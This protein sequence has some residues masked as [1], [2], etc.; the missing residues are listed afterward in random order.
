[1][2]DVSAGGMCCWGRGAGG[3]GPGVVTLGSGENRH[4][5]NEEAWMPQWVHS[6]NSRIQGFKDAQSSRAKETS[7]AAGAAG[8]QRQD[9]SNER[10]LAGAP[11]SPYCYV[12][13][14]HLAS[15]LSFPGGLLLHPSLFLESS[16]CRTCR[17]WQE[18]IAPSKAPC[19]FHFKR[20]PSPD[21]DLRRYLGS[22]WGA[23]YSA[24][25]R[26]IC[27]MGPRPNE[28]LPYP[29]ALRFLRRG[30]QPPTFSRH[31]LGPLPKVTGTAAD[32]CQDL[33]AGASLVAHSPAPAVH[34]SFLH[35]RPSLGS[36]RD[37]AFA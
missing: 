17:G 33:R 12:I 15:F 28:G 34:P 13:P 19:P 1:M 35:G 22:A 8:S 5:N 4:T 16:I 10:E 29:V 14:G 27:H 2:S 11:L 24:P 25:R 9:S 32:R 26:P 30:C 20:G 37:A 36:L 18:D 31:G 21:A 23:A 6:V 3:G 7:L